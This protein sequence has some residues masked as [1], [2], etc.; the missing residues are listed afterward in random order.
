MLIGVM[1]VYSI[2]DGKSNLISVCFNVK[3]FQENISQFYSICFAVKYLV[4]NKIFLVNQI[5]LS[6]YM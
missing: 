1:R 6:K 4:K 5:N 2:V 3:Y